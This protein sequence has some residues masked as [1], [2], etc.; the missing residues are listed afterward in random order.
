MDKYY[1]FALPLERIDIMK[2]YLLISSLVLITCG[3]TGC[4]TAAKWSNTTRTYIQCSY[5]ISPV[6]TNRPGHKRTRKRKKLL[7]KH[8]KELLKK[9]RRASRY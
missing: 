7:R 2:K 6:A 5:D 1:I 9:Q 8:R 4:Y 3:T